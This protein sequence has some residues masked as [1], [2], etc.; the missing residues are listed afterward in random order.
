MSEGLLNQLKDLGPAGAAKVEAFVRMSAA[1]LQR[2]NSVFDSSS[3]VGN[4]AADKLVSS[5]ARAGYQTS[6]GFSEGIDTEAAERAMYELGEKSLTSLQE[7]LDIH[8][9]SRK[10]YDLGVNTILG[11]SE[12]IKD[13]AAT[14]ELMMTIADFG[15][16]IGEAYKEATSD[17]YLDDKIYL[18][19]GAYEPV[20]RP[21]VDMSGVE[22]GINSFFANRQFSLSGTIG[23]AMA[24]QN[25]G[26]SA[27]AIMITT[28]VKELGSRVDRLNNSVNELRQGQAE[29]RNAIRG[30][31]I[32]LDTGALVG[33][34]VN[35]MDSALGS[36]AVKVRRRKG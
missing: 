9:P 12:G 1:Q 13:Q 16:K 15:L 14:D 20:I 2:A 36:K 31:D 23:N 27:D 19:Q 21:L 5:Y 4:Y 35:Q 32:R 17:K 10:T 7:A 28:A 6:L 8:S 3:K 30:I 29:T 25:K 26:P 11:Y 34:I 33:G 24:A 22:A 18:D